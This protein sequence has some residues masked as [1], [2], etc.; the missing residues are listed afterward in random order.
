[1]LAVELAG[2]SETYA[3][4]PSGSVSGARKITLFPGE[5]VERIGIWRRLFRLLITLRN[6]DTVFCGIPY[7]APDVILLS[8]LL[9]LLG[10][11]VVA[12]SDSKFDDFPRSARFELFKGALLRPYSAVLVSGART[13][14]Y[15][16]FLGFAHRP[17]ELGYDTVGVSRLRRDAELTTKAGNIDHA[18][19]PFVFVG[20]FVAKKNISSL[21]SGYAAYAKAEENPHRLVL[22]GDGPL[23]PDLSR[24]VR[25]AGISHL[26]DFPG[27]L[28]S[29]DVARLMSRSLALVLL[30]S[31]EQWGLVIN[32]AVALGLPVISSYA[33][34]ACD[35]LV[36][37]LINGFVVEAQDHAAVANAMCELARSESLW[38]S[39]AEASLARAGLADVERF[40]DACVAL[41][42]PA[43]V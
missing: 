10:I 13:R 35:S 22:A 6:C 20:R 11:K 42:G 40:A 28:S 5:V 7:S 23:G 4:G 36:T 39:M 24:Q 34:G 8:W 1:M 29:G 38:R 16:R 32:E 37:N 41:S 26:V 30:S 17:I 2:S 25:D 14:S 27:F 12:M 19:R 33:P 15:L 9:P 18:D 3:W 43:S 21:I 31:S